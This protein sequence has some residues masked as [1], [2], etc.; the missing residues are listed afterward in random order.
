MKIQVWLRVA[1]SHLRFKWMRMAMEDCSRLQAPRLNLWKIGAGS[2]IFLERFGLYAYECTCDGQAG[3][4][5]FLKRFGFIALRKSRPL[6]CK[7]ADHISKTN[8]RVI[9]DGERA[10]CEIMLRELYARLC[11]KSW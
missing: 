4:F 11:R 6:H 3:R 1:I 10:G 5:I 9:E 8:F 2:F 7:R